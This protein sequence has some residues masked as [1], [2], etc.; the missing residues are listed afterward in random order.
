MRALYTRDSRVLGDYMRHQDPA[1]YVERF[2][3]GKVFIETMQAAGLVRPE[4]NP[5]SLSY[6]LSIIAYGFTSIETII[7]ATQAPPV[8]AVAIALDVLLAHGI[9]LEGGDSE[10]GKRVLR[11]GVAVINRQY[12]AVSDGQPDQPENP[13]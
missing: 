13:S 7:P 5:E 4:V 1:R 8:E 9:V 11:Q 12:E 6:L 2:G 3:F 10:A